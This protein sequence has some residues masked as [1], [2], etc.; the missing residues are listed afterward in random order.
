LCEAKGNSWAAEDERNYVPSR[1]KPMV[2]TVLMIGG[3]GLNAREY[4]PVDPAR[5]RRSGDVQSE[6]DK[7]RSQNEK[8]K[9]E[10]VNDRKFFV[11]PNKVNVNFTLGQSLL[12]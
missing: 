7:E 10:K 2:R 8:V 4:S 3:P 6:A 9:V 11:K 1:P 5:A 12:E